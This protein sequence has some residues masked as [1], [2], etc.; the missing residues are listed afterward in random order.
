MAD[1]TIINCS[2]QGNI[3]TGVSECGAY[4][5]GDYFGTFVTKKGTTIPN[6]TTFLA[7]LKEAVQANNL[8]PFKGYD[9]RNAHEDNVINTSSIG[10]MQLV[11]LGKPMFEIDLTSSICEM[12][13]VSKINN[14]S[15][16]WD[17]W[18]V[19]E[20]AIVCATNA[21]GDFVGFD[22]NLVHLETTKL[23]QGADLQMKTMKAQLRSS[24]QYNEGMTLIPITTALAEV[25]ELT[26]IIGLKIAVS[27]TN[28]T[29]LAV[30]I[31]DACS[32]NGVAG[33]TDDADWTLLGTQATPSSI[34]AVVDNGNGSYTVTVGTLADNDTVG[35]K[36]AETGFESVL[37]D[38][39]YYGGSSELV[40]VNV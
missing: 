24:T 7:K 6:D 34:S 30:T 38:G 21:D 5:T 35:I 23:K 13:A 22:C 40:T 36:I 33:F 10:N 11:R 26:G 16:R 15:D 1:N 12:K 25:K 9:Y 3:F 39:S 28:A 8:L 37:L 2:A 4:N 19:Y 18:N 32:G 29:T 31:T 14:S 27:V 17:L 20:N